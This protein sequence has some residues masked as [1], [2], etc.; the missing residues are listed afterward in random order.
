MAITFRPFQFN[1][2]AQLDALT[3]FIFGLYA[4]D[5]WGLP[6]TEQKIKNTLVFLEKHPDCGQIYMFQQDEDYVGY[7]ILIHFWSNE[8]GGILLD[9]DELFV[10][11]GHR[12]QGIGKTFID[13]LSTNCAE[14]VI[15]FSL[16]VAPENT[17]AIEFYHRIGF[18]P[19]KNKQLVRFL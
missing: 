11:E 9:I 18:R 2:Q 8:Y 4:E 19:E 5:D 10:A 1:H 14:N 7:A 6:M 17:R 15:G 16:V 12:N 13:W 3:E